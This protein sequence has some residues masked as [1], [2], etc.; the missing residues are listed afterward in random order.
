MF[1]RPPDDE[2]GS[3]LLAERQ[4]MRRVL[5]VLADQLREDILK[6]YVRYDA[7]P[8]VTSLDL[9]SRIP[10]AEQYIA[11][12]RAIP[13]LELPPASF[14]VTNF[15]PVLLAHARLILGRPQR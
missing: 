2:N 10:L 1:G 4:G 6:A 8:I 7:M 3:L 12:F 11:A 13:G 5:D 15:E 14:L 9:Y